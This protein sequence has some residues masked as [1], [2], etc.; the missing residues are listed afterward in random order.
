MKS[1]I[2]AY[3]AMLVCANI[4]D[5]WEGKFRSA[6]NDLA[7]AAASCDDIDSIKSLIACAGERAYHT[8]AARLRATEDAFSRRMLLFHESS[9]VSIVTH[10]MEALIRLQGETRTIMD[11][12]LRNF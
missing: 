1:A 7:Q 3:L 12:M 8:K 9:L 11:V 6:H 4:D 10:A 2:D 5:S